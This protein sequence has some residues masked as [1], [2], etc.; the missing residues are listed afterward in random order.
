[1]I[2]KGK[3]FL[4]DYNDPANKSAAHSLMNHYLNR[5]EE[6]AKVTRDFA[7]DSFIMHNKPWPD[8][9]FNPK[10]DNAWSNILKS[11]YQT[12]DYKKLN[13]NS[14]HDPLMAKMATMKFLEKLMGV[15]ERNQNNKNIQQQMQQ[16]QQNQQSQPTSPQGNQ[17]NQTQGQEPFDFEEFINA[18]S[19]TQESNPGTC[20]NISQQMVRA[21]QEG[22]QETAKMAALA[23]GFT[24][25][26]IPILKF[27]DADDIRRALSNKIVVA[28]MQILKK[29][30]SLSEGRSGSKPSPTRGLP[31]GSKTMRSFSEIPDIVP[32]ELLNEDLL[33]YK[34]A[35][36]KVQVR[37]RFSSMA[38]YLVYLDVSGSMEF[39]SFEM[40]GKRVPNVSYAAACVIALAMATKRKGGSLILKPFGSEVYDPISD[41]MEIIKAALTLEANDGTNITKVLNDALEHNDKKVVIVSDG[42]DRVEEDILKAASHEDISFVLLNTGAGNIEKYIPC[43]KVKA[44]NGNFLM[45]A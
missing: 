4:A 23:R 14:A 26:G 21:A 44:V 37:E 40:D 39:G 22:A 34:L 27:G 17:P 13:N 36:R 43:K 11:Y 10:S 9:L 25:F 8:I 38:D 42:V 33:A 30:A 15:G 16:M 41:Y 1:M 20:N 31:V 24:H 29:V 2:T 6:K 18:L 3:T 28:L 5:K 35:G 45:E 32:T 7:T 12:D 19:Q